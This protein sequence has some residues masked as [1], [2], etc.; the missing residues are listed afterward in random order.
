MVLLVG[1]TGA[2][3]GGLCHFV[4]QQVCGRNFVAILLKLNTYWQVDQR[5]FRSPVV[6]VN[7]PRAKG[8]LEYCMPFSSVFFGPVST[9]RWR[10]SRLQLRVG[11]RVYFGGERLKLSAFMNRLLCGG[12]AL[13]QRFG[14][15]SV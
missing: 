14:S 4:A 3:V 8:A 5:L 9:F 10:I 13:C 12:A 2:S 6:P 7:S 1:K 15:E 11:S